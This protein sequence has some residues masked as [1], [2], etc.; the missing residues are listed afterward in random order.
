MKVWMGAV[1]LIAA[2]QLVGC[3]HSSSSSGPPAAPTFTIG[4]TVSGLA[5]TGL[6]LQLNGGG[7]LA[8]NAPGAPFTFAASLATGAMYNVTVLTDPSGPTQACTVTGG[9]G[10]VGSANVTT[11]SVT[12]V[13]A[14][15]IGGTVSGL[16]GQGL[17]LQDNGGDN[18]PI[19]ANG[20]FTFATP[21]ATGLTYNVTVLSNTPSQTCT[22][23]GG[24]GTVGT[25]NVTS[26]N[27]GCTVGFS[28]A[29]SGPLATQ[30][31][32]LKNTGQNAFAD[33]G[34]VTGMDI[35]VEPVF[36][37]GG[38]GFGVITAVVDTGMEIAHEDLAANVVPGG[39]W[40]FN[41]STTDPTNTVDTTG[42]HGTS[43]SGLIAM[44]RNT[45]GGIGVAPGASLKGF[46]FLSSTQSEAF[47][48]DSLG[49]STA[50]PKSDDV[51]VF[52]QSF[53]ISTVNDVPI[54]TTLEAQYL[55][56]V[57]TLR[58]GKGALYVKAAGNGFLNIDP[59]KFPNNC[60]AAQA[61]QSVVSGTF[62]GI[63]CE[64]ANFDPENAIP[65][66][67]VVGA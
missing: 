8:I 29:A 18:L 47:L 33:I 4:G 62:T 60:I 35:N 46:N 7:N 67:V 55:S 25:A 12:C 9:N 45:V 6:V 40:N 52:N 22:V 51:F 41:T 20:P 24:T 58:G 31:W 64:N 19:G 36:T 56:G 42:D 38:S 3:S 61:T 23:S 1:V 34:G 21:I 15:R 13:P 32:H 59:V 37:S 17:V 11:V 39:S 54:D 27:V 57:T 26:V 30:E 28:I 43:V 53:G 49:G 50:S 66:Q 16:S 48:I 5:G 65:Y 14:S 44:A 63:S 10:V 2:T